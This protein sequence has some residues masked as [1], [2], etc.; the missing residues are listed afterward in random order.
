MSGKVLVRKGKKAFVKELDREVTV[1][2]QKTYYVEDT[3]KDYHTQSGLIKQK[4]LKKSGRVLSNTGKE[5]FVFSPKFIDHYLRISRSAQIIPLKDI[6]LIVADTG[7]DCTSR[8]VDAGAG[9]GALACFLAHIAKEVTTYDV[10]DDFLK[11]VRKNKAM[12]KLSNLKV[13]RG[14]IYKKL[15]ESKVDLVTLDLPEPWK[16][17]PNV[18]KALKPGGHLVVYNP[19]LPQIADFVEALRSHDNMLYLKTVEVIERQW[20]VDG[21]KVRPKSTGI[22]HSGFMV[23]SRKMG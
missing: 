7:L 21:R 4:D 13:K 3:H 19:S 23:F 6:G 20:E 15:D 14:D 22:G 10:R 16:A 9:S 11:I 17:L 2:K 12:L 18:I 1:I 5:F 8:V